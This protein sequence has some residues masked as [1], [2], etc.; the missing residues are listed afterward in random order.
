MVD[1]K[2]CA[3]ILAAG[4]SSR[5]GAAKQLL[6]IKDKKLLEYVLELVLEHSFEKVIVVLGHKAKEIKEGIDCASTRVC[7]VYNPDYRLG[8]ST[9]FVTAIDHIDSPFQSVMFFL[10]DQ[11]FIESETVS[12]V[13]EEGRSRVRE[14]SAPFVIRPIYDEKPGHPIYWGNFKKIDFSTLTGDTGGRGLLQFVEKVN[15]VVKDRGILFDIDTLEDYQRALQW[16]S[17]KVYF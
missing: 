6:R 15:F 5:M 16:V 10:G 13:L 14:G 1:H 7:W 3:V 12:T 4:T 8:Q 11:P 9:S 2:V 17:Q